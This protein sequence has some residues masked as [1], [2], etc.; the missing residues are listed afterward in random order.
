M[1]KTESHLINGAELSLTMLV[2]DLKAYYELLGVLLLIL[3]T[4]LLFGILTLYAT[5]S[6]FACIVFTI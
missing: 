1:T 5:K 3:M 2:M 6:V 4:V